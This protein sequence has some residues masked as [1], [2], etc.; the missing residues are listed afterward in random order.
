MLIFPFSIEVEA[1]WAI[2]VESKAKLLLLQ[3]QLRETTTEKQQTRA[4]I[5]KAQCVLHL[6]KNDSCAEVFKLKDKSPAIVAKQKS[7]NFSLDELRSLEDFHIPT[8]LVCKQYLQS[9]HSSCASIYH[10]LFLVLCR[11][12]GFSPAFCFCSLFFLWH[13]ISCLLYLFV[14]CFHL[15]F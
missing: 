15:I 2:F 8:T 10:G 14:F 5:N 6:Q 3:K 1:L 9:Y 7:L 4:M 11:F 13:L 12:R